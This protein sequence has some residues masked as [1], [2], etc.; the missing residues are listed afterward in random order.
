ML[1]K[2]EQQDLEDLYEIAGNLTSGMVKADGVDLDIYGNDVAT[3]FCAQIIS[4]KEKARINK[5]MV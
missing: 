3:W 4:L 2:S 1:T 5:E